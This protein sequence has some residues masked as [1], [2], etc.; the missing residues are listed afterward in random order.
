MVARNLAA[1]T[2]TQAPPSLARRVAL[3]ARGWMRT[4]VGLPRA[5]TPADF[6]SWSRYGA[7]V[8]AQVVRDAALSVQQVQMGLST[9]SD[10]IGQLERAA[11]GVPALTPG[12]PGSGVGEFPR[13]RSSAPVGGGAVLSQQQ[14]I[15]GMVEQVLERLR[16]TPASARLPSTLPGKH[17]AI[18]VSSA[19]D[20]ERDQEAT[21]E[22]RIRGARMAVASDFE[23]VQT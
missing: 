14:I 10:R 9:L 22:A 1:H 13:R 17:E 7:T 3:H 18:R 20:W 23:P 2:G 6:D 21:D 19:E 12:A 11:I 15:D 4:L 16:N 5:P 8:A